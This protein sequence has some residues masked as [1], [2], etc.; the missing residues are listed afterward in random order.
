MLVM[1][2]QTNQNMDEGIDTVILTLDDTVVDIEL[3]IDTTVKQLEILLLTNFQDYLRFFIASGERKYSID[4]SEVFQCFSY[5]H[6]IIRISTK[7][8]VSIFKELQ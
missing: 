7:I 1:A 3:F 6:N 2:H 5:S 4:I 8:F